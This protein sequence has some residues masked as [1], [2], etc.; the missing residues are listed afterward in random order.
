MNIYSLEVRMYEKKV[1]MY[2]CMYLCMFVF[3]FFFTVH[4]PCAEA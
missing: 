1:R 2:A 3:V 4:N